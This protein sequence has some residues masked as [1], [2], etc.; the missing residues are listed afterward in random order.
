MPPSHNADTEAFPS[1]HPGLRRFGMMLRVNFKRT[2][3]S[4]VRYIFAVAGQ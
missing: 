3:G 2:T 4:G 1:L